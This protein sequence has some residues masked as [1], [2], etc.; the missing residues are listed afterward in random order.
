MWKP[1]VCILFLIISL[2]SCESEK[3]VLTL[4][5]WQ[6]QLTV[7]DGE[8]L[9]FNFKLIQEGEGYSAEVY[10]AS[11]VINV[12]EITVDKDS[13]LF[14]LPVFEAYLKARYTPETMIGVFFNETLDRTLKFKASYGKN[15]RFDDL[16][17]PKKSVSGVWET[18]FMPNT[19]E[20]YLGQGIFVQTDR[21]VT[22]TFRTTTGDYRF[23]EGI[24]TGDSLKLSA[25]DGSHA[26]LFKAKIT[27]TTLQGI[28]YSGNHYKA[29]FKAKRNE[30]FELPDEDSLTYLKEGYST[31]DFAFPDATGQLRSLADASFQG[32]PVVVQIMGT[33]CP[34]CL[35]ESKFF[36]VFLEENP[37]LDVAFVGLAFEYAKTPEKAFSGIQRLKDRLGITYP[38]LLAQHGTADKDIAQE[39][40]PMLN[41]VL[42]YPTTIFIDK[43]GKVRKIKT[44]FNGPATGHNYEIFKKEFKDFLSVLA[45]E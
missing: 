37:A 44:G 2:F 23:L 41:H 19:A 34:N 38:I 27:D 32:K 16:S 43:K 5:I 10:N 33:W 8:I 24:V 4:G 25:F 28:F 36:E 42:S 13:I 45:Q 39:K 40:L 7:M 17:Q 18:Q 29:P 30:I 22:G 14:Y 26:F 35:D 31:F 11:E 21:K 20:E 6:G 1:F 15:A 9:P 3:S 12:T